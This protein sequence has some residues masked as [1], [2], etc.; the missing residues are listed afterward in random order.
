MHMFCLWTEAGI[1]AENPG[2]HMENVQTKKEYKEL[3]YHIFALRQQ[4]PA[5]NAIFQ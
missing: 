2:W 1:P 5:T 4:T 3:N